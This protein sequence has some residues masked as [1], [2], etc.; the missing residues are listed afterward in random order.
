M[1]GSVLKICGFFLCCRMIPQARGTSRG[2]NLQFHA[3]TCH[4]LLRYEPVGSGESP[5]R[6]TLGSLARTHALTTWVAATAHPLRLS[7]PVVGE[8]RP[9]SRPP[10]HRWLR[11]PRGAPRCA[12]LSSSTTASP[13]YAT[14]A[15]VP[16]SHLP[17]AILQG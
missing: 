10:S 13:W 14:P 16:T 5:L 17:L 9:S 1:C 4:L 3:E 15:S 8:P 6:F 11:R 2:P 7:L 12:P